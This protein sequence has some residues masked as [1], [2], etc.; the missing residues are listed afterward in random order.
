METTLLIIYFLIGIA[1]GI[2]NIG[3]I[4][5]YEIVKYTILNNQPDWLFF[6][7]SIIVWWAAV[8]ATLSIYRGHPWKWPV[9]GVTY[10]V[11]NN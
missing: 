2:Y 9:R 10:D 7:V 5:G 1:A 8:P 6:I 11:S 4:H 3:K